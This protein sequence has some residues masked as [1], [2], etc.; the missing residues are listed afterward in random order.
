VPLGGTNDSP[1]R[2]ACSLASTGRAVV[3]L[4][5]LL[6]GA[7]DERTRGSARAAARTR[8]FGADLALRAPEP[9]AELNRSEILLAADVHV[10][11]TLGSVAGINDPEVLRCVALTVA[12]AREGHAFVELEPADAEL[13][14]AAGA[15]LVAGG[16]A[17]ERRARCG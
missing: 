1:S 14:L 4:S 7:R 12:A 16:A 15:A 17:P 9:L 13:I 2:A 3:A 10:A 8:P 5:D 11:S 6:A